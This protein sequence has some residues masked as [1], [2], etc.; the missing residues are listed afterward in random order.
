MKLHFEDEILLNY[1]IAS[2]L[3][4]NCWYKYQ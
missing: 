3:K 2:S 1:E 4:L